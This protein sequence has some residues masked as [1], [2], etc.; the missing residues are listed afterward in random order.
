MSGPEQKRSYSREEV[1]EI[2]ARALSRHG[3]PDKVDHRELLEA[4]KEV[5]IPAADLEA[6]AAEI[7]QERA[8]QAEQNLDRE[9]LLARRHRAR[10][11]F[12]WHL[13]VFILVNA[14]L[15]VIDRL[16][17]GGIWFFWPLLGWG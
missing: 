8:Q 13:A 10:R 16:T 5:G 4:A 15:Y 2:L 17:T 7:A 9:D 14:F 12:E 6:A 11:G 3:N 1:E